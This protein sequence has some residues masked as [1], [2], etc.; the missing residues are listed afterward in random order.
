PK[1]PA[2][3]DKTGG[4]GMGNFS[5]ENIKPTT[6]PVIVATITSYTCSPS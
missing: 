4:A 5:N 2:I 1:I 3:P 6:I